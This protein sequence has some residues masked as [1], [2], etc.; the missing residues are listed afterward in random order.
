MLH[1]SIIES[2][3][4]FQP[5]ALFYCLSASNV[6]IINQQQCK[7]TGFATSTAVAKRE[8]WEEQHNVNIP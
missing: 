6:L 8:K 3:S 1:N 7:L 2:V 5:Q 4:L